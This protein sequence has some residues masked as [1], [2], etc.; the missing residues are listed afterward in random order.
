MRLAVSVSTPANTLLAARVR[1]L[2]TVL[3]LLLTAGGALAQ[4]VYPNRP[5]RIVVPTAPGA[6]R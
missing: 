5:I 1:P 3:P 4:E 2:L 6:P